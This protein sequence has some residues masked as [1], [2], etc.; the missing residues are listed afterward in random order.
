[1]NRSGRKPDKI[2]VD[3]GSNFYNKL[4]KLW[5]H[6]NGNEMYL[7]H[8][9]RKLVVAERFFRILKTKIY[10]HMTAVS[11]NGYTEKLDDIVDKYNN[12]YHKTVKMKP[13][14]V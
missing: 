4:K 11:K 2:W 8:S 5:F 1:M 12:T 7:T 9:E 14:D 13:A 10:K 6:D 3:Q